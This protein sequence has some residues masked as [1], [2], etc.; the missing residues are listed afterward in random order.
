L[1]HEAGV[2]PEL[3]VVDSFPDKPG[4]RGLGELTADELETLWPERR[5]ATSEALAAAA[6]AWHA[7]RASEPEGLA[8]LA[9]DGSPQLPFRGPAVGRLP[10]GLPSP[11]DGLSRPERNALTAIADGARTPIRAFV[12]AQAL[13]EASFIGDAWFF[14]ALAALGRGDSRLVETD[15]GEELP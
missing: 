1:A 2:A 11:A 7:F 12:A 15:D 4:F 3:V 14:R 5:R 8:R 13:E 6:A 10:E 9:P